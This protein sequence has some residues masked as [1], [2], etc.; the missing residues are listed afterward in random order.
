LVSY[1]KELQNHQCQKPNPNFPH[2]IDAINYK[3]NWNDFSAKKPGGD[4][5][6][7]GIQP[8][9]VQP[10]AKEKHEGS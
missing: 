9:R 8:R 5:I 2:T 3:S 4:V 1:R 6:G 10:V 7:K